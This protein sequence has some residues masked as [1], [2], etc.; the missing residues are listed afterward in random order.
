VYV[1]GH[2]F[3]AKV[4]EIGAQWVPTLSAW[5]LVTPEFQKEIVKLEPSIRGFV[6]SQTHIFLNIC[7]KEF[8]SYKTH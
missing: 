2:E 6:Y 7:P 3:E 5:D 4:K 8:G 1:I